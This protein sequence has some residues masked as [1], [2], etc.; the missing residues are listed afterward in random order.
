MTAL[1]PPPS[2]A[3]EA[4]KWAHRLLMLQAY[5][6][7]VDAGLSEPV[8]RKEIRTI[9]RDAAKHLTDAARYDIKVL[10]LKQRAELEDRKRHKAAAKLEK[11]P[12]PGA[13]KVIPIRRDG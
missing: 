2:D 8:R 1:G 12:P 5:E 11:R 4:A 10:I 7:L 3:M 9:M 13:A 6:T